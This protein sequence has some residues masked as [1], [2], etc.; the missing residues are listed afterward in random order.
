MQA[1]LAAPP[2][3]VV[4]GLRPL[5]MATM[6]SAFHEGRFADGLAQ[7]IDAVD[8]LLVQHFPLGESVVN[9]NELPDAP[10]RR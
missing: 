4:A 9:P 8:A 10:M 5:D 3:N 1:E 6:Q 7:A 2:E